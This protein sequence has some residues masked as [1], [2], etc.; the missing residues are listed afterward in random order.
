MYEMSSVSKVKAVNN[1]DSQQHA[2]IYDALIL[3]ARLRQALVSSRSLGQRGLKVAALETCDGVPAFFSRWCHQGYVCPAGEGTAGYLAY[4]KDWLQQIGAHVLIPASDG[5]I[6]LLQQHRAALERQTRIALAVD[7]ALAIAVNKER[8][9]AMAQELGLHVPRGMTVSSVSDV[10]AAVHE[11]GLPAVIKPLESWVSCEQQRVASQLV[12]SLD[13]ALRAVEALTCSG[14]AVLFQQ[15]L[16]G[17]REAISFLFANGEIYARFAQWAK[18]TEPPLGGQS[19]LRQS[20][21]VPS[22]SGEQAERLIRA[23]GL[24][25]YSEV[26]FRRDSSGRP[27][28]MEINPRLSASVEIAVRSGV[29]FPLLLY[30]WACGGPIQKIERYRVGGWM[31]YL[32]GDLMTTLETFQQ[33]GRPGVSSPGRAA[34]DFCL[35]FMQPMDYD[36]VDWHDPLP[37]LHATADFTTRW[38]GGA[39]QKRFV[40]IRRKY[41]F[42]G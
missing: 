28:L 9:L 16:T 29:D 36:Y 41:E 38:V 27:F 19:V 32:R 8:T 15:F 2:G 12:V 42:N 39:V 23:I 17:R 40:R 5:T 7:N 31:R 14:G 33:R 25:G 24:D 11:I 3:D 21:A 1:R 20:I 35:S 6:A 22:D 30:Q 13:E 26:E 10:Y 34:M 18:R 37:A 4:L